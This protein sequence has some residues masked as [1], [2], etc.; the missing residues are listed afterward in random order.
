VSQPDQELAKKYAVTAAFFLVA[1]ST[2]ELNEIAAM[3]DGGFL[4]TNVGTVLPL[5]EAI[6]AHECWREKRGGPRERSC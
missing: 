5:S 4:N 1:V 3:V 6:A 2:S